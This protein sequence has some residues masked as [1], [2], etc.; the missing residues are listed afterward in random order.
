MST[1]I[2]V[3]DTVQINNLS[4]PSGGAIT[5]NTNKVNAGTIASGQGIVGGLY[6]YLL[7]PATNNN[8][9]GAELSLLAGGTSSPTMNTLS[10]FTG[11][12]IPANTLVQGRYIRLKCFGTYSTTGATSPV[13]VNIKFNT[14][15][16]ATNIGVGVASGTFQTGAGPFSWNIEAMCYMV[17]ATN[18]I[19][20]GSVVLGNNN[21]A[22]TVS[23][24]PSF[25]S[26]A[27]GVA[28]VPTSLGNICASWTMVNFATNTFQ[29]LGA[30]LE[31]LN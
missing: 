28:I 3:I 24:T 31:I 5:L 17:S 4:I 7:T 12:Q 22:T 30:T 8:T 18:I 15:A 6:S 9:T 10:T 1:G 13:T 2:Q 26:P 19:C 27:A 25:L 11:F 20:S 21:P 23:G 14:L 29:C 16:A